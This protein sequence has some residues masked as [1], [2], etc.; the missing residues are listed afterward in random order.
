MHALGRELDSP[1]KREIPEIPNH[2]PPTLQV[3]LIEKL[4]RVVF[5]RFNLLCLGA[6]GL[7]VWQ[8]AF[9]FLRREAQS[10]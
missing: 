4:R 8:V 9:N 6:Q 2:R 1:S 5:F 7:T 3:N 10:E